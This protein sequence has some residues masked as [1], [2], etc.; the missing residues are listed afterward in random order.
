MASRP[1]ADFNPVLNRTASKP[2]RQVSW[3]T[4]LIA[5]VA[6]VNLVLVLF[7]LSYIPWRDLYLRHIPSIVAFYDPFKGIEP[8]RVT[9][10]YLNTV[11]ELEQQLHQVEPQAPEAERLLEDL[12]NQSVTMINEN[13]FMVASKVGTFAKIK[14]RIRQHI[15]TESAKEAF[16]TFWSSEYLVSNGVDKEL[17][18]FDHQIRPL[19]QVNYFRDLDDTG[20]FVDKF[21]RIDIFFT[22]FFSIDFLIRTFLMSA[23]SP[24]INWLG[25]MVRRWYDVLLLLPFWRWL[26]VIP[27]T[28]RLHQANLVNLEGVLADI[29]YE[30]VAYLADKV[31]KFVM[32]RFINHTQYAIEQGNV[33]RFIL[34]PRKYITINN[35]NEPE[36]IVDRFMQ[37]IIYKV[38]PQVQPEME[39]LLHHSLQAA[40]KQSNFYKDFQ[41]LPVIGNMPVE[42]TEQLANN[43]AQAAVSVLKYSYTDTKAREVF[44]HLT[45]N[46][47]AALRREIQDDKTL[48]ELQLLLS[49]WLEEL[50]L[51]YVQ[52]SMAI[53]SKAIL[54]EVEQLHQAAD[55]NSYEL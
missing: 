3:W 48:S 1:M 36:V 23:Q 17:S 8:H 37:L 27:V 33:A 14:K 4:K 38:L 42:A 26:R 39:A 30:P 29:T 20:H 49:D 35:I 40:F 25:A 34:K 5:I 11:D 51:N 22:A 53:D 28:L 47:Q 19:I 52:S 18:F 21:W 41:K 7:N 6:V 15:G 13:P 16:K 50:K 2:S 9:Q 12:R 44:D 55:R 46:F 43:L 31:S 24:E 10:K 54:A 32:V 45:Q